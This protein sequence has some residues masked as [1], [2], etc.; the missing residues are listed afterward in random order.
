MNKAAQENVCRQILTIMETYREQEKEGYVD[1][2][3][4]LEHM[5]DVWRLLAEWDEQLRAIMSQLDPKYT[6][7]FTLVFK[8]D[9]REFNG[10]NPFTTDSPWGRPYAAALGD[11]LKE[12]EEL[13]TGDI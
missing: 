2:P 9:L 1:T 11:A 7:S 4:G 5:G 10:G 6:K 8:G 3:G 12:L 13:H